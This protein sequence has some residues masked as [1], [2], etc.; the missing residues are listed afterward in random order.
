M[1]WTSSGRETVQGFFS[2]MGVASSVSKRRASGYPNTGGQNGLVSYLSNCCCLNRPYF[3][4]FQRGDQRLVQT[5]TDVLI[6]KSIRL[7][8]WWTLNKIFIA[9]SNFAL[10]YDFENAYLVRVDLPRRAPPPSSLEI[11]H[12]FL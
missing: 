9:H 12:V 2:L 11:A 5:K 6:S 1:T 8:P 7:V 3:A 4:L 10:R